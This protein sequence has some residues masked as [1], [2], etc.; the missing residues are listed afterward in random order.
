M[1]QQNQSIEK[2][3]QE[4]Q[5]AV[6]ERLKLLRISR[7]GHGTSEYRIAK[8]LGFADTTLY[9]IENGHSLPTRRTL[10]SLKEVYQMTNQEFSDLIRETERIRR[11]KKDLKESRGY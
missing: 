2:H 4:L 1:Q 8:S 3:I 6:G 11:L 5:E 9:K 10:K 7:V